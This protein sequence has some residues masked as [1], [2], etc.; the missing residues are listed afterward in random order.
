MLA[1]G[2]AEWPMKKKEF[3]KYNNSITRNNVNV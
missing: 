3:K 2:K 1:V